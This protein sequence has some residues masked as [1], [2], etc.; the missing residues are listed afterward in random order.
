M[1]ITMIAGTFYLMFLFGGLGFRPSVFATLVIVVFYVGLAG[2]GIPI[3]RAGCGALLVLIAALAG[4]P[5]HHLNSLCCAFFAI[6]I[7]SPQSLWSIGFQL[8]FLCVLSLILILPLFARVSAWRLSL[9]SSLAVLFGT[10]PVVLFYFNIFSPVSVLANIV[11]IPLCDAALFTALFALLFSGV[12]F[13]NTVFV[14]ISSWIIGGSLAWV[15]YLSTW[16]WG[17]WF[18]E[19]PSFLWLAAYYASLGMILYFYKKNFRQKRFFM[20]ISI[21]AWIGLTAS[22]FTGSGEKGFELTFLA[23]GRNQ[24]VH[25]HFTNGAQWIINA[26]RNFPSDQGEWLIAPFLRN[27]GAQRLEGILLTDFSKK[28]AGGLVSVLRDFP[29]RYLLYPGSFLCVLDGFSKTLRALGRRAKAIRQ[30][31]EV[32]MEKEKMRVIAQT[33]KG[34]VLLVASGPW[35]IFIISRWEAELFDGLWAH[36]NSDE[37]HA[38]FLPPPAQDIPSGFYN[39]ISL[40]RPLLAVFPDA[41]PDFVT[42]LAAYGVPCLNLKRTGALKFKRNGPRLELT[43]FLNGPLGF[44]SYS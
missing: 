1:N 20:L 4:R 11:A 15:K 9:G 19:R 8:S 6:L 26:G 13:L 7:W 16:R 39:W 43:S 10:F 42:H 23:G 28:H 31:D 2:A 29:V 12:P 24:L 18:F 41:D 36:V 35:R 40:R 5:A 34:T 25:T 22:F 33:Q 27:R 21:C 3:Q 44:Y 30:G 38:I 32:L 37:V 17:Y 14:K